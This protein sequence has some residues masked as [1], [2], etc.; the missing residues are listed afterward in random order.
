[1]YSHVYLTI[2]SKQSIKYNT[3]RITNIITDMIEFIPSQHFE[4]VNKNNQESDE[5]KCEYTTCQVCYLD[6]DE[7]FMIYTH[8]NMWLIYTQCNI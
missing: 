8:N 2:H 4:E 5:I 3:D 1:M 6:F 7:V